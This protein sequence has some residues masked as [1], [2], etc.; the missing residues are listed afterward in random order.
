MGFALEQ[1]VSLFSLEIAQ[2]KEYDVALVDP[3]DGLSEL[4]MLDFGATYQTFFRSLPLMWA[5][6]FCPS[7]HCASS[8]PLP[9]PVS[10]RVLNLEICIPSIFNTWAYSR[11]S[12]VV[13]A[14]GLPTQ[15]LAIFLEGKLALLVI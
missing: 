13:D 11:I 1:H 2:R 5:S 14:G 3:V 10:A 12:S 15:T 6:R 4:E 8:R 7:K 9:E